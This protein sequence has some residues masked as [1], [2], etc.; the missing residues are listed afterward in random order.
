M[1][2]PPSA[3]C[4]KARGSAKQDDILLTECSVEVAKE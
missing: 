4:L 2:F 3:A 1:A